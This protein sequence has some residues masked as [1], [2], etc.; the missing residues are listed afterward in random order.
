MRRFRA[1]PIGSRP[2]WIELMVP[3]VLCLLC[4]IVRQVKIKFAFRR[5]SY[6]R[7]FE[8]YALE[9]SQHMTIKDV[10]RH[11]RVS[12][13]VIKD[14]QKRSLIRRFSHPQLHKLKQIAIDEI[15]IGKRAPLCDHRS[16]LEKWRRSFCR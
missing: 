16:R 4:G 1:V 3:R 11:L 5:R 10:A 13:D 12:W 15:S 2:V 8:R 14:I 6:T 9:L 7:S